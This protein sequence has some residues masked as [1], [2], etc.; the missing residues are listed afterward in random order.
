MRDAIGGLVNIQV[1]LVFIVIVSGYLAFSVN[2]TKAFRVKNK[3]ITTLEEYNGVL[4]DKATT[5]IRSYMTQIGYSIPNGDFKNQTNCPND[6]AT[7]INDYAVCPTD[8]NETVTGEKREYFT[9]VTYV[10]IDI[11]VINKILPR[12]ASV[13]SV[14][15]QTK[16]ITME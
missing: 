12:L 13:F 4:D 5:S 3:I 16:L 15:G 6:L 9:V 8:A 7:G 10:N 11:P 2:Y 14:S 1:I